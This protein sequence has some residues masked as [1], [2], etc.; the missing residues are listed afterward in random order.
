MGLDPAGSLRVVVSALKTKLTGLSTAVAT[1]VT[2]SDNIL[3]AIGKLQAQIKKANGLYNPIIGLYESGGKYNQAH[4]IPHVSG[5]ASI[6]SGTVFYFPY[7][8]HADWT[9]PLAEINV[10]TAGAGAKVQIAFYASD[11]SN[12]PDARLLLSSIIDCST[13]GDKSVTASITL[14]EKK[15]YWVGVLVT[16]NTIN[17]RS[18]ASQVL[19]P[20]GGMSSA[21]G[22]PPTVYFGTGQSVLA[23][24]GAEIMALQKLSYF[25]P[26]V[27]LSAA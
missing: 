23:T 25:A 3:Q 26:V 21:S 20:I 16:G 9:A 5:N 18:L 17:L 12:N 14:A 2:E 22:S 4:A 27:A 13:T 6:N 11:A 1:A 8:S 15:L 10:Q 7:P 19:R 24:T